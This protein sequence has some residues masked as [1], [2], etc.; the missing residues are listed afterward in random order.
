MTHRQSPI[1]IH[2]YHTAQQALAIGWHK[3]RYV[4]HAPLHFLQQLSQVVIVEGQSAHQKCVQN[5]TTRPNV[6]F[7]AI[8]F[9]TLKLRNEYFIAIY[10][11]NFIQVCFVSYSELCNALL[12]SVVTL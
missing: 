11:F 10:I 12:C 8:V 2:F 4:E 7:P 6:R 5:D 9:F 3:V 1:R